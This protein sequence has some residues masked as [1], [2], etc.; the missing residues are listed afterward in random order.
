[1]DYNTIK[2]KYKRNDE[3]NHVDNDDNNHV[4]VHHERNLH[5]YAPTF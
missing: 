1:M 4:V 3:Y 5:G 2:C